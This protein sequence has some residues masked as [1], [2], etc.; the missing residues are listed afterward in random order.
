MP[1]TEPTMR[2]PR[3]RLLRTVI[4]F[5]GKILIFML[6]RV[7]ITGRENLPKNGRGVI[8]IGNHVDATDGILLALFT[9]YRAEAMV[10]ADIPFPAFIQ[11]VLN[12]YG[13]IKVYR[14]AQGGNATKEALS[15]LN[16][17]GAV[18]LFPEGGVWRA[19]G[20]S[21]H[22]GAAWLSQKAQAQIVPIGLGGT[23]GAFAAAFKLKRPH[24]QMHIGEPLPPVP[25]TARYDK[26]YLQQ[27][28]D[29]MMERVLM[30]A[31]D[32]NVQ[33]TVDTDALQFDFKIQIIPENN[34]S[35]EKVKMPELSADQSLALGLLYY[36]MT[37]LNTFRDNLQLPVEAILDTKTPHSGQ[38]IADAISA[39]LAHID[40]DNPEFFKYRFG[41]KQAQ[42]IRAGFEQMQQIATQ[43]AGQQMVLSPEW[44]EVEA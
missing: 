31:P 30:L 22:T 14:G 6:C 29:A 16:Q 13:Y 35:A 41:Y 26:A 32:N 42:E 9:P 24:L 18:I 40:E 17:G 2:Y 43:A 11:V 23:R 3:R 44:S 38:D 1:E 37:L 21:Y 7:T 28:V 20:K 15:V 12:L 25:E 10:A 4:R 27:H 19:P 8:L 33:K 36:D 5:I 34:S 39:M